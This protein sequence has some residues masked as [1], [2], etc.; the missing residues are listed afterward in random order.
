MIISSTEVLG[1]S[2]YGEQGP[3]EPLQNNASLLAVEDT[4]AWF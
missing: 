4:E 1:P 2:S 3:S